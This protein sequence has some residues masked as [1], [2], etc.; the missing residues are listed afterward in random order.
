MTLHRF[1]LFTF[2]F[3]ILSL[4]PVMADDVTARH[5]QRERTIN[6]LQDDLKT[7]P[8][9]ADLWLHLGFAYRKTDKIDDAQKAFEKAVSLDANNRD[10]L[11]MLGLIYEKK[12]DTQKALETWKR[13]VAVENDAEKKNIGQKHIHH[14]S[15]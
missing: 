13:Y 6:A 5:E 11:Y 9:N 12:H 1:I 15:Q 10:G 14:L 3:L 2:S 7:D 4:G 8:T